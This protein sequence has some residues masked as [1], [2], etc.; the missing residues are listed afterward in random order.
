MSQEFQRSGPNSVTSTEGFSVD[1]IPAGGVIYRGPDGVI[2]IDS[3]L[4]VKPTFGM[5]IYEGSHANRGLEN[6]D[7]IEIKAIFDRIAEALQ[8][9]GYRVERS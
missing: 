6:K 5:V 7:S 4:L 2:S 8:F 3:E 9:L 1:V